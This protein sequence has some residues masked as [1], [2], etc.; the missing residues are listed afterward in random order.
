MSLIPSITIIGAGISGLSAAQ[1]LYKN[2]FTDI[3]ILEARDRI[4]GRINT[5][6]RDMKFKFEEG[7]QWLHGDRNN[8]LENVIQSNKIQ[9]TSSG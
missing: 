2:G 5:I 7:A 8:P 3:T 4:G 6:K 9:M 1:T